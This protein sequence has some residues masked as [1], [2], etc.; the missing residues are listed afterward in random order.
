MSL[1]ICKLWAL[2]PD[3]CSPSAGGVFS[4]TK[5]SVPS[6]HTSHV[7]STRSTGTLRILSVRLLDVVVIRGWLPETCTRTDALYLSPESLLSL[8]VLSL[9]LRSLPVRLPAL[10]DRSSTERPLS[11]SAGCVAMETFPCLS[12]HISAFVMPGLPEWFMTFGCGGLPFTVLPPPPRG[13]GGC[14][15]GGFFGVTP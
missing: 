3:F 15:R 12:W 10:G 4:E 13:D 1:H 2:S 9:S 7:A 5:Y 6:S 14:R 8:S 11:L